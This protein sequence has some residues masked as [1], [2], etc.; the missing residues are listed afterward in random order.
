MLEPHG[1][2]DDAAELTL[3]SGSQIKS[4]TAHQ[5]DG[6]DIVIIE[7]LAGRKLAFAIS[8]NADTQK[9]HMV[10]IDGKAFEWKGFASLIIGDDERE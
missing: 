1:M 6:K 2:F 3:R 9:Q 8:Y 7:T 10:K 4:F 5:H